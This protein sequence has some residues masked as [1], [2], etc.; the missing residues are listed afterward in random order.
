[1]IR[2]SMAFDHSGSRGEKSEKS[3]SQVDYPHENGLKVKKT[4]D[5]RYMVDIHTEMV[6]VTGFVAIGNGWEYRGI[7]IRFTF[8]FF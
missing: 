3:S 8:S 7:R 6:R 2:E 1:M 5:F 4:H